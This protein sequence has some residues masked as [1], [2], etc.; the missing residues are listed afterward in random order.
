MQQATAV[1]YGLTS[2]DGHRRILLL[3]LSIDVENLLTIFPRREFSM[4]RLR[5]DDLLFKLEDLLS[6]NRCESTFGETARAE[7]RCQG[8]IPDSDQRVVSLS[9]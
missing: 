5:E 6:S 3:N 2:S 4:W 1:K 9:S 8:L 7:N